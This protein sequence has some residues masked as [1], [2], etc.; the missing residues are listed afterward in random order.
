LNERDSSFS[1]FRLKKMLTRSLADHL[2][3]ISADE[4]AICADHASIDA[5]ASFWC[6]SLLPF[7]ADVRV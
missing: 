1:I 6:I 4:F 2:L 3:V 5:I 7:D